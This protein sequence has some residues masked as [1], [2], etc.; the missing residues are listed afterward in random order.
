MDLHVLHNV[1]ATNI[2]P[3]AAPWSGAVTEPA[4]LNSLSML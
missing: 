3:V 1:L 4:G 2:N